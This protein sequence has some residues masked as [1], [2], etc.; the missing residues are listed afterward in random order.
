MNF[1]AYSYSRDLEKFFKQV[2]PIGNTSIKIYSQGI[3]GKFD[4]LLLPNSLSYV[5]D[6][7]NFLRGLKKNCYPTSRIIVVYF[8]F[9]WKPILDLAT[10][11]G[12]R[13]QDP[14]EP[15]WFTKQDITNLFYLEG[16]D[17]VKH[18]KRLLLPM[19]LGFFSN[20]VN[21]FLAQLPIINNFCISTYQ[22]FRPIPPQKEYSVSI[23]IP[24]R[25]EEGN[26]K[27]ILKKIPRIGKSVEVI[28]VEGHSKDKTY[29]VIKR[30]IANYKG[31]TKSSVYKQKGV[32][33]ANAV[34]L[35]FRKAINDILVV[36]DAD[37]AV[38]PKDLSKFYRV[39]ADGYGEVANGSRLVYP[40][41]K[42]AMRTLNYIGNKIFSSIFTFLLGQPIK[43]TL[44]GT[45]VLFRKHYAK[46]AQNRDT[47]GNFDPFGDFDLL[48]G[49]TILNLKIIEVPVRYRERSYG[50][51]N[52][53]R[54]IH[55]WLLL[56]MAIIAA[57]KIKFV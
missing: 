48:F 18:G 6:A 54:F 38:N 16:F 25:N 21:S 52:I 17:E 36:L 20:F 37:L 24:A 40:M 55:G 46:I 53:S 34:Q 33:K 5:E 27:G 8:N 23:I 35:G 45:K 1:F 11:A 44:C 31:S 30:E 14:K 3:S 39:L 26:I 41:K 47:L 42:Q 19:H 49:A 50:K 56:K 28:F 2:V 10:F 29:Q 32:G 9:F 4:Y 12:L 57:R 51:T 43:D 22:I 13:K 7:Q 15:N